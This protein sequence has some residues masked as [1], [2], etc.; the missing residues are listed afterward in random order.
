MGPSNSRLPVTLSFSRRHFE[1][2]KALKKVRVYDVPISFAS[3]ARL[4]TG[5]TASIASSSR[6]VFKL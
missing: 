2:R 1:S 5:E 6:L 3:A 4:Q